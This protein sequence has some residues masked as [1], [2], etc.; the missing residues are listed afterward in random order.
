MASGRPFAPESDECAW[1]QREIEDMRDCFDVGN[2]W[3]TG[4]HEYV[5]RECWEE[6]D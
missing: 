1:C 3:M 5:C 2:P 6:R 4:K